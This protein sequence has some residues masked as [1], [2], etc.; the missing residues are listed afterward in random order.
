M[1]SPAKTTRTSTMTTISSPPNITTGD[2]QD[3]FQAF[4]MRPVIRDFKLTAELFAS[5]GDIVLICGRSNQERQGMLLVSYEIP[6]TTA[7]VTAS[8]RLVKV[9]RLAKKSVT[10]LETIPILKIALL[11]S[12]GIIS[13]LDIDSLVEITTLSAGNFTLFSTW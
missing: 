12:D 11:L 13:L 7:S 10:Q 6:S 8:I 4:Q 9:I 1:S 5:N 3:D 2:A